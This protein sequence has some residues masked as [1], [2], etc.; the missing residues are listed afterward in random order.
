MNSRGIRTGIIAKLVTSAAYSE[1]ILG[2]LKKTGG[3]TR[4]KL[5]V[6]HRWKY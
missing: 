3:K 1:E 2:F 5:H 4:I 6:Y